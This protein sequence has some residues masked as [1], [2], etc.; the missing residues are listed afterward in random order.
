MNGE[1]LVSCGV[2]LLA[3]AVVIGL[4]AAV[5]RRMSGR[6]LNRQL[7]AEFGSKRH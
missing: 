1:Q 3:A 5:W 2:V 7:E 6:R 4:A